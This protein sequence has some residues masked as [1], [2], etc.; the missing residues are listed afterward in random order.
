MAT[1]GRCGHYHAR[2]SPGVNVCRSGHTWE[3]SRGCSPGYERGFLIRKRRDEAC[4]HFEPKE[5]EDE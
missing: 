3:P 1:C 4:D 5:A 2:Y